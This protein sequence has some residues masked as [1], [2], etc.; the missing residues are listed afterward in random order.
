MPKSPRQNSKPV[1]DKPFALSEDASL[2]PKVRKRN[3]VL[4]EIIRTERDYIRD[5][6]VL[7]EVL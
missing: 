7:R 2:D 6:A 5:L 3:M 4:N 1:S